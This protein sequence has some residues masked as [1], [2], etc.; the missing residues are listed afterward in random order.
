MKKIKLRIGIIATVMVSVFMTACSK[1]EIEEPLPIELSESDGAEMPDF[2]PEP[3]ESLQEESAGSVEDENEIPDWVTVYSDFLS[4][5]KNLLS[6]L[7]EEGEGGIRGFITGFYLY[8][9]NDDK[10]PELFVQK[11]MI[12]DYIYTYVDGNVEMR[13]RIIYD[14]FGKS[15][16]GFDSESGDVYSFTLDLG[17][18]TDRCTEL[19]KLSLINNT[20]DIYDGVE[21]I[22]SALYGD[23][24]TAD[25]YYSVEWENAIPSENNQITTEEFYKIAERFVPFDFHQITDENIEKYITS[26]YMDVVQEY[27]LEDYAGKMQELIQEFNDKGHPRPVKG[28]KVVTPENAI[29]G[30]DFVGKVYCDLDSL[31]CYRESDI[32]PEFDEAWKN[33]YWKWEKDNEKFDGSSEIW[34]D[35]DFSSFG[36]IEWP[37]HEAPILYIN[38]GAAASLYN[39]YGIIDNNVVQ[40][41]SSEIEGMAANKVRLI[42]NTEY[43]V[44]HSFY[45]GM[46]FGSLHG[47]LYCIKSGS[48]ENIW[49]FDWSYEFE[50]NSEINYDNI[51]WNRSYDNLD[52]TF[53]GQQ[54]SAYEGMAKIDELLGKGASEQIMACVKYTDGK[55]NGPLSFSDDDSITDMYTWDEWIY[56]LDSF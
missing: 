5:H 27:S 25:G 54:L 10:I 1:E 24:E 7:M 38:V 26:D 55:D 4:E 16:F 14:A 48:V 50:D 2:I 51:P 3:Y 52:S 37:G 21:R 39:Y 46:S 36:F 41:A 34:E 42:N 13:N 28:G 49:S 15:Y 8:D 22:Y 29:M 53:L 40:I 45:D 31:E 43:Y 44:V 35:R 12:A 19:S 11:N 47:S 6:L 30:E 23:M 32:V 17:T 33:I 56:A 9:L 20:D 18:G